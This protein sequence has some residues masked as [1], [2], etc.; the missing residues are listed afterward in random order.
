[1]RP[2]LLA[3]R[4][5]IIRPIIRLSC[6]APTSTEAAASSTQKP[7]SRLPDDG[8]RL[9]DFIGMS[10]DE[11]RNEN[12]ASEEPVAAIGGTL[13]VEGVEAARFRRKKLEPKPSWLKAEPPKGE[14]YERLKNTVKGLGLATVCEE[15][16]CPNIGECWG[17]KQGT[18]TATIM[19]MGDTCTRGC[20]FCAVKTSRTPP[21]LDPDE[22]RKVAEAIHKW[23]LDYVVLTSVDRDDLPDGG[24]A[25]IAETV[26]RLKT[27][28]K[29]PLVEVLTPDFQG[30]LEL[31]ALVANSGLDVYAHNVETV[32]ALTPFVRDYRAGYR[33]SLKVLE[34]AKKVRPNLITKSSIMLGCGE[35]DEQVR[36]TL[37]DLREH[38]VDVV[39][40]GQYLRPS[41]R[42]MKVAAYITPDKFQHWREEAE[43]MGFLYVASGPLVRSSY[44]AGEFFLEHH[45]KA[46]A[47]AH[48]QAQTQAQGQ[49]Q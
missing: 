39:T 44:R 32:E 19:L 11:V 27:G 41:P 23:G 46:R 48:A 43:A 13:G 28:D 33:Q 1:M 47:K 4:R 5:A 45:L 29:V 21:P 24:A 8:L 17:G 31:V 22:P 42:H 15:A 25:H 14:N 10:K 34:H 7:K 49:V 3:G 20:R 37:R 38:G 16:R 6:G 12:A 9:E 30:K 36:Q 35:T 2:A 18:A 26:R 40:F